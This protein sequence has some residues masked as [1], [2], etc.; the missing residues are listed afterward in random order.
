MS[1]KRILKMLDEEKFPK[2][3]ATVNEGKKPDERR[4]YYAFFGG[5]RNEPFLEFYTPLP[6]EEWTPDFGYLDK[7]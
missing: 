1:L 6:H 4:K 5:E 7:E 2:P 3:S